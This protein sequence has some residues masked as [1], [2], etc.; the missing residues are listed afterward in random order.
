M[1]H[2]RTLQELSA[3]K[4]SKKLGKWNDS[5]GTIKTEIELEPNKSKRVKL[6]YWH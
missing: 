3:K 4:L 6:F 2:Y 5:I 1:G